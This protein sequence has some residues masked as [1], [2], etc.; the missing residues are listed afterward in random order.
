[1]PG[2]GASPGCSQLLRST[3]PPRVLVCERPSGA[4]QAPK[5]AGI[6]LRQDDPGPRNSRPQDRPW[7]I[8][9]VPEIGRQLF[10]LPP[11]DYHGCEEG[12][13]GLPGP[14]AFRIGNRIKRSVVMNLRRLYRSLLLL[15]AGAVMFQSTGS[16]SSQ[17]LNSLAT[18]L[19]S[20]V[21]S[22]ISSGI[23]AY[24]SGLTSSAT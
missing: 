19:S 8:P 18:T 12:R 21:S 10:A 11:V 15:A 16:C 13:V 9:A 24:L 1:V 5:E 2:S 3:V 4:R 23:A 17:L 22:A 6:Q 7:P 20:A 14:R